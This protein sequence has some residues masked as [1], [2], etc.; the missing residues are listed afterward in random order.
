MAGCLS[1]SG[2]PDTQRHDPP[3]RKFDDIELF[4]DEGLAESIASITCNSP[5]SADELTLYLLIILDALGETAPKG[6]TRTIKQSVRFA[7]QSTETFEAALELY[8]LGQRGM[9]GGPLPPKDLIRQA[10]QAFTN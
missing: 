4:D 7:F 8:M 2:N 10:I 9:P 3:V 1:R 5:E 6:A